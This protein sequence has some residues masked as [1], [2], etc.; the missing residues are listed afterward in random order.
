MV[1]PG[2]DA[3]AAP[4]GLASY[5]DAHFACTCSATKLPSAVRSALHQSLRAILERVRQRIAADVADRQRLTLLFEDEI[6][7]AIAMRNRAGSHVSGNA[8]ALV[9]RGS[10]Q[11]GKLRNRVVVGLA[12]REA[13]IGQ[14]AQA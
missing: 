13:D 1:W 8:H 5:F 7:A 2:C 3:P 14:H 9:K 10:L 11:R 12:L 4:V 6:H